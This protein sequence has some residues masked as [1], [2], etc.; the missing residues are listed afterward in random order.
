MKTYNIGSG[1]CLYRGRLALHFISLQ[2]YIEK[3]G[4]GNQQELIWHETHISHSPMSSPIV[5]KCSRKMLKAIV[6]EKLLDN[7]RAG[8]LSAEGFLRGFLEE[9]TPEQE[10]WVVVGSESAAGKTVNA[11]AYW[12]SLCHQG[13]VKTFKH[14]PCNCSTCR[15]K[16]SAVLVRVAAPNIRRQG[17]ARVGGAK[18]PHR[19][20]RKGGSAGSQG[21][22]RVSFVESEDDGGDGAEEPGNPDEEDDEIDLTLLCLGREKRR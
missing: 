19:D 13:W 11:A 9:D 15:Q 1:W 4:A 20:G 12:C 14:R 21:R 18:Q 6:E 16:C 5:D 3:S 7:K 10:M 22:R 2:P 17:G 8:I